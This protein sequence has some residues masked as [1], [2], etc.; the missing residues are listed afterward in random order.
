MSTTTSNLETEIMDRLDR[1]EAILEQLYL[2]LVE[3][4]KQSRIVIPAPQK[5]SSFVD[6]DEAA[7]LL[8]ISVTKSRTHTRRLAWY[9]KNGFLIKFFGKSRYHYSRSEIMA[10]AEKIKKCEVPVPPVL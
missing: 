2:I 4:N 3:M 10:L 8:G 1:F 9:R 5:E 7:Q 6:A